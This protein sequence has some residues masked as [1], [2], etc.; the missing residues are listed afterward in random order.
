MVTLIKKKLSQAEIEVI[1]YLLKN[2]PQILV[3]SGAISFT[4]YINYFINTVY[5]F[6]RQN[7]KS[8]LFVIKEKKIFGMAL[9]RFLE[10]D[11]KFFRIPIGCIE[12]ILMDENQKEEKINQIG[13]K[14]LSKCIRLAKELGIRILYI[15][16][17]SKR[18]SLVNTLNT[19]SFKF[20]C[21]E[22]EGVSTEKDTPYLY[23]K[24]ERL[25]TE[26]KFRNYKKDDYSQIIKIAIEIT[27]DI[28]SKFSLTPYLPS[29][30]KNNYYLESIKNCCL[31][32]NADNIFVA[33]KK[34][35]VLGFVCYRYDRIFEESLG[36]KM[37]FLVMGGVLRSEHRNKVGTHLLNWT[38]KQVLKN[39]EII[40]GKV[41]LHN[42]PMMRFILGRR[43]THSFR[44]LYTF[45]KKL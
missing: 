13:E 28:N 37:S 6:L 43:F 12:Y 24:E 2:Y 23:N 34:G 41:Y 8:Y 33:V 22:L 42:L 9:L 20:I 15:S 7:K 38:H 32:V 26:Y 39:S 21:G 36:K 16:I 44:I 25:D 5:Y 30:Q 17:D 19:L 29:I 1:P 45:C 18:H 4:D 11:S 10:W 3:S 40:L 14:V 27:K 31:G 35:S